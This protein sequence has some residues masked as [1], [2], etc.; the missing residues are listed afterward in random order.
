MRRQRNR[1]QGKEQDQTTA[2][3]LG[4]IEKSNMTDEEIKIMIIKILELKKKK[5]Y[6]S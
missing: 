2:R 1:P 5:R 4:K 6:W 3:D